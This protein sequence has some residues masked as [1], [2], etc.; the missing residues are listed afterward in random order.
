[1]SKTPESKTF[2]VSD[3]SRN[4]YGFVVLTSGIDTTAFESNPVMLHM[5]QR[6]KVFG[7][8]ANLHKEE[9]KLFADPVFDVASQDDQI[10]FVAG[11]VERDVLK[12]C[13]IGIDIQEV[14]WNDGLSLYVAT[15]SVLEEISIVDIGGNRNAIR[16]YSNGKPLSEVELQNKLATLAAP[17]SLDTIQT[18]N[19]PVHMELKKTAV[20]LGLPETATEQEVE[21]ALAALAAEKGYKK[22]FEDLTT[23]LATKQKTESDTLIADAI[24]DKRISAEMKGSYEALFALDFDHTKAVLSRLNKPVDLTQFAKTGETTLASKTTEDAAKLYDTMDKAGTL[25]KLKSDN[26]NEYGRLFEARWG[27][28]PTA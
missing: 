26:V 5:H 18:T 20:S 9:G 3:E 23:T 7:S 10:V 14:E 19:T 28:K 22:K 24:A 11:Q 8:W 1:M 17:P 27:R 16:L 21:T 4:S 15:K 2:L 12:A 13:S 25:A 6:G